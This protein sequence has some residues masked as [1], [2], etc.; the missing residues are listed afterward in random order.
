VR[1]VVSRLMT[2]D[3]RRFRTCARL[4]PAR[5]VKSQSSVAAIRETFSSLE[6]DAVP[7]QCLNVR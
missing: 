3:S 6:T 4:A 5:G 2:S 7:V 1:T